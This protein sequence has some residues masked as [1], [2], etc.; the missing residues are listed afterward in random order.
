MKNSLRLKEIKKIVENIAYYSK[1]LVK[2]IKLS[3]LLGNNKAKFYFIFNFY[4]IDFV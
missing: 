2:D 4:Q 1:C 3:N